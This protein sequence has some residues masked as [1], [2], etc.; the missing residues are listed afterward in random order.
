[1]GGGGDDKSTHLGEVVK[2]ILQA[3]V[4]GVEVVD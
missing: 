3:T 4:D 1:M 2:D